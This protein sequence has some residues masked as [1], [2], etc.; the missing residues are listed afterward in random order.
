[1]IPKQNR[2]SIVAKVIYLYHPK[3]KCSLW[4]IKKNTFNIAVVI[5]SA[6]QTLSQEILRLQ[7]Q[8]LAMKPKVCWRPSYIKSVFKNSLLVFVKAHS[9]HNCFCNFNEWNN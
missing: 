2:L 1:M 7:A 5:E 4:P 6:K 3:R 8:N 9:S